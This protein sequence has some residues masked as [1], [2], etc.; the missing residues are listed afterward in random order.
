VIYLN[1]FTQNMTVHNLKM[2]ISAMILNKE[3]MQ[4]VIPTKMFNALR[5]YCIGYWKFNINN[6]DLNNFVFW[7]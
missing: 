6:I 1:I 4:Y 2:T 7:T 5:M 3:N